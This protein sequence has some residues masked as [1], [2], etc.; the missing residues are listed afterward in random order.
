MAGGKG[1][2]PLTYKF[3][4]GIIFNLKKYAID[5]IL[6]FLSFLCTPPTYPLL[7][8]QTISYHSPNTPDSFIFHDFAHVVFSNRD[9]LKMSSAYSKFKRQLKCHFLCQTFPHDLRTPDVLTSLCFSLCYS[10]YLFIFTADIVQV[11]HT[12]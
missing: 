4:V 10:T 5:K 3:A 9:T 8:P 6:N 11:N 2:K 1:R 7:E 12:L